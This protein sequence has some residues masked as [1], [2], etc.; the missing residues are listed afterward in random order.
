MVASRAD[1]VADIVDDG[2]IFQQLS[3]LS[4]QLMQ[5]LKFHKQSAGKA[6]HLVGMACIIVVS[7]CDLQDSAQF[8]I[9]NN[10]TNEEQINGSGI[11]DADA[12][13]VFCLSGYRK[14][15]S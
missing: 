13:S 5:R 1:I 11:P 3:L 4:S 9:H 2:R 15:R 12:G 7:A 8:G 6:L 10:P 14:K